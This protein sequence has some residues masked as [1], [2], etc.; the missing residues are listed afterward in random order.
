MADLSWSGGGGGGLSES[1]H[2]GCV[3]GIQG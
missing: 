1:G 2:F 3:E